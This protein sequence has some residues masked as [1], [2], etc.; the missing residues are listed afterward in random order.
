MPGARARAASH[1]R[2]NSAAD[3]LDGVKVADV[4][5]VEDDTCREASCARGVA[6]FGTSFE[7]VNRVG[8]AVAETSSSGDGHGGVATR[9]TDG[10]AGLN[11]S[12]MAFFGLAAISHGRHDTNLPSAPVDAPAEVSRCRRL[13]AAAPPGVDVMRLGSRILGIGSPREAPD[14]CNPRLSRNSMLPLLPSLVTLL[15]AM[16]GLAVTVLMPVPAIAGKAAPR[17][18]RDSWLGRTLRV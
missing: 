1:S 9:P 11:A 6:D 8:A 12:E 16:V 18:R 17:G 2:C 3:L 13:A 7:G 14:S 15:L 4:T 5:G 10:V